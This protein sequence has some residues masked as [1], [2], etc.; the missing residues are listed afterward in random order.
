MAQVT[1]K[2][3]LGGTPRKIYIYIYVCPYLKESPNHMVN[4]GPTILSTPL[5]TNIA[6]E[7][8]P[9]KHVF[10]TIEWGFSIA[11]FILGSVTS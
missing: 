3:H 2:N 11:M 7:H 5:N 6:I 1:P 4:W 9:F 10:P 8:G